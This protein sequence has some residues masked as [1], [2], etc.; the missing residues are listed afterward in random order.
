MAGP[1]CSCGAAHLKLKMRLQGPSA[2]NWMESAIF[3]MA[4]ES[5]R[6]IICVWQV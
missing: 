2:A 5:I 4:I 1:K 3:P 6:L